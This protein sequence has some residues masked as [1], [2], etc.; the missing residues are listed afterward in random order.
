M[1][2]AFTFNDLSAREFCLNI[3]IIDDQL[4]EAS[5]DFFIC[6]S[7]D[8]FQA[9]DI[10]FTPT[11]VSVNITDNDGT[12]LATIIIILYMELILSHLLITVAEFQFSQPS[13]NVIEGQSEVVNICLELVNG[14]LAKDILINI[15]IAARQENKAGCKI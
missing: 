7:T 10:Q 13:Y 15:S 14:T 9:L 2:D 5:E 4:V 12:K 6:T 1:S 8:Q 3:S 11:C